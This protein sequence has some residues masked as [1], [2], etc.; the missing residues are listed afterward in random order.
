[1]TM[2][3]RGLQVLAGVT[4]VTSLV[5][6][7]LVAARP[8]PT[9]AATPDPWAGAAA[10]GSG[11]ILLAGFS[12]ALN[13]TAFEGFQVNELS[14]LIYD[15]GRGA[16]YTVADRAGAVQSHVFTLRLPFNGTAPASPTV[17]AVTGL[18]DPNGNP[19]TGANFDGEAVVMERP[20]GWLIASEGGSAA[21]RQP[22]IRSFALTGTSN[23]TVPLPANLNIGTNNLSLE[24]L[25]L[26]PGGRRLFTIMEGP[27][28]ADGRTADLRSRLRLQRF[29]RG[30]AG[31][32]AAAAQHYY[33]TEPG[34]SPTDLGI[35]EMLA[36]SDE[37]LLV[38]E[39]GFVAGQGNTIRIFE[40][41]LT[42]AADVTGA[43]DLGAGGLTPLPKRLF[44]DLADC[45]A[46]DATAAP[47]AVQ[48][49]PLLDNFEAVALGPELPGGRQALVL[50]SDDNGSEQQTTRL[51]VLAVRRALLEG[52]R[53]R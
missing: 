10:C 42:G 50:L 12:D 49:N 14:G 18:G 1:M 34:R 35:A 26:A 9:P 51:V 15:S 20:D 43:S 13:K 31:G 25:A 17:Q 28:A 33:L 52:A 16:Y 46:G 53:P 37:R 22:E 3:Q 29:D 38:L 32:Y 47:G 11:D 45:P 36:L 24:S 21:G 44:L 7:G 48:A 41:D 30:T 5:G 8:A 40:V 39:R 23:G 2:V 19:Y 4:V 27:L 6:A